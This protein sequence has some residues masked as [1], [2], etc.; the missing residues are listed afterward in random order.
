[1]AS[2]SRPRVPSYMSRGMGM[3]SAPMNG[4]GD[5]PGLGRTAFTFTTLG[6]ARRPARRAPMPPRLCSDAMVRGAKELDCVMG[7]M[8][9]TLGGAFRH[10]AAGVQGLT[11]VHF[12]A[13]LEPF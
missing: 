3:L 7:L 1:M 8:D 2:T 13:Q 11:L 5:A 12:S 4:A 10:D 9:P 6:R